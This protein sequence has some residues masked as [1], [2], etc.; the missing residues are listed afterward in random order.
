MKTIFY[1]LTVFLISMTLAKAQGTVIAKDSKSEW[2]FRG[3]VSAFLLGSESAKKLP[4][5]NT[6]E[7]LRDILE[8][9][10]PELVKSLY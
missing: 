9:A 10:I 2:D 1:M 5:C 6:Y 8:K 7:E 3:E 4:S